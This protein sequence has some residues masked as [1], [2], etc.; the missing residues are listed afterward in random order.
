MDT[1]YFGPDSITWQVN[2]EMTVLF[3]GARALLMHAAHPLIAAGARQTS[4]YSRDPWARL[5]RTL[6]LQSTVTFGTR[7][8]AQQAADRINKLHYKVN[9]VDPITGERYDGVDP[10]LLLWVHAALEVSSLWFF[11][12]T[13]RTL[14][15]EE[16]Q[17]YHE[18]SLVAAELVLLAPGYVPATIE[19]LEI[20]VERVVASDRLMMTDVS[21][22][23]ADIIRSGPVPRSVKWVWGFI[24]LAAFGTLPPP[25]RTLYG[26]R[27]NRRRQTWLDFNLSVLA[28]IR[29]LLPNRLRII[30]PARWAEAII[31]G[32]TTKS[33]TEMMRPTTR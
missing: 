23:V 21:S 29:P 2:R 7:Q 17:R 22:D 30:G 28:K 6:Q 31:A 14:T 25:L 8:E 13:V 12:R 27:W 3:G 20:Y 10:D 4:M 32:K 1:G 18:E 5:V 11:E 26:V 15:R 19:E 33:L 16:R 24:S 9:G